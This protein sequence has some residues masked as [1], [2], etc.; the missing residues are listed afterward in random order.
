ME[1]GGGFCPV[2]YAQLADDVMHVNFDGMLGQAK[3]RSYV[4]VLQSP[5][6]KFQDL[7]LAIR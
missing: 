1:Y 7:R 6:G 4:L 2:M 3:R 5:R